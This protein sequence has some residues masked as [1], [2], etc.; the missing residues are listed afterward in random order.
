MSEDLPKSRK[1]W[2]TPAQYK[3][4][5]NMAFELRLSMDD[6]L[7]EAFKQ[8]VINYIRS[9]GEPYTRDEITKLFLEEW[10]R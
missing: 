9:K 7:I 4:L 8:Y 2:F 5:K 3:I 6:L 10:L 1:L